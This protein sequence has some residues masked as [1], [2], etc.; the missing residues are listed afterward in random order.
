M[1]VPRKACPVVVRELAGRKEVL[2]FHHPSAGCH[3]RSTTETIYPFGIAGLLEPL[4][5]RNY[6]AEIINL[7]S[8]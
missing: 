4:L 8:I 1:S 2:A 3:I 5:S 6:P 7:P